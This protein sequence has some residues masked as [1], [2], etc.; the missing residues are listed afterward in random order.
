MTGSRVVEAEQDDAD[1][2]SGRCRK[3][4]A[5]IEVKRDHDPLLGEA[6][7]EDVAVRHALKALVAEVNRVVAGRA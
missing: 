7:L 4:L 1:D 5:E 2:L 6:F 3:D